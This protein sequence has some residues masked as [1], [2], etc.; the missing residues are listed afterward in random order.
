MIRHL[1]LI[2][3]F[4][5]LTQS[6]HALIVEFK[7][8]AEV[9]D[10]SV[11]LGDIVDF[12]S[13]NDLS[14]ALA[15]QIVG[16]SPPP[17]ESTSIS[18]RNVIQA[19]VPE[20]APGTDIVWEGSATVNVTRSSIRITPS[21]ISQ[22]IDD[23]LRENSHKLPDAEIRFI[24]KSLPL[25]FLLPKGELSWEIFPSDPNIVGSKRFSLIF[26][27]DGRVRKNMSVRGE[28]EMLA[29]VA[30]TTSPL[31]KGTVLSTANLTMAT[32]DISSMK[33]PCFDISQVQGKII[34][35]S[36][37]SGKPLSLSNVVFPPMILKG[38]LVRMVV[39]H[40]SM[41]LTATGIARSNGKLDDTIR[42]QN[43]NSKKTVY[44]R[45]A[46]PGLVEVTL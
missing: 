4:F 15:S 8:S 16:Q 7:P 34:N 5:A 3:V 27:V 25:P 37:K 41:H 18:S 9:R 21:K 1:F 39:N 35:R 30:I 20:L 36:I 24:A 26:R 6:A 19:L 17:G 14:R 13:E 33:S 2:L 32:Q 12:D 42:V 11:T 10:V 45:V 46:A 38:Q 23:Y 29:S 22:I 28:L 44:C 31:K 43:V 40:N